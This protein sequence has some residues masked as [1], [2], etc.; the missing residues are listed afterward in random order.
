MNFIT[1]RHNC[2]SYRTICEV[3]DSSSCQ[4]RRIIFTNFKNPD[5]QKYDYVQSSKYFFMML[6][7]LVFTNGTFDGIVLAMNSTGMNWRHITKTPMGTMKKLLGFVQ[8]SKSPLGHSAV[9]SSNRESM[10]FFL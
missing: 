3:P 1:R 5:P 10:P 7:H 4:K 2:L 6:E 9:G 8:V